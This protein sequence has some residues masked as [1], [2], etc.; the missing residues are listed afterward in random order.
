[1]EGRGLGCRN[2][3][4]RGERYGERGTLIFALLGNHCDLVP[5]RRVNM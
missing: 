2:D 1:M 5:F 4:E 3:K